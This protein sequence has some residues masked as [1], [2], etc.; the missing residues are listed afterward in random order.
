LLCKLAAK[1]GAHVPEFPGLDR[2]KAELN[3]IKG[4]D[5]CA[6]LSIDTYVTAKELAE[7]D[8]ESIGLMATLVQ[9]IYAKP[10][11]NFNESV[12]AYLV[13]SDAIVNKPV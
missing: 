10:V 6:Q 13:N 2:A 7:L 9:F 12:R 4:L 11:K 1:Y 3:C 5:A 8:A